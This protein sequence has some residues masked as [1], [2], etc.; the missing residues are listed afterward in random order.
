MW[1][2]TPTL[3]SSLS[4]LTSFITLIM[5]IPINKFSHLELTIPTPVELKWPLLKKWCLLYYG[6]MLLMKPL[7]LTKTNLNRSIWKDLYSKDIT[8]VW[9]RPFY[10][11]YSIFLPSWMWFAITCFSALDC[12]W[13]DFS[14][15]TPATRRIAQ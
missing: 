1:W 12:L 5:W 15:Q 14:I 3:Y 2:R 11:L 4:P 6:K 13:L 8:K 7:H 9:H 10:S